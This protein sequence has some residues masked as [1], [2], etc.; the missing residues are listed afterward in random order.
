M[1]V[2]ELL[3]ALTGDKPVRVDLTV[4]EGASAKTYRIESNEVDILDSTTKALTIDTIAV[5]VDGK[6]GYL[7]AT[8]SAG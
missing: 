8:A 5:A 1:T 2:A 3:T 6:V 4:G 7:V